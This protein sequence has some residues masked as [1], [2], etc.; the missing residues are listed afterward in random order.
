MWWFREKLDICRLHLA[1]FFLGRFF[2]WVVWMGGEV[3]CSVRGI[4][5]AAFFFFSFSFPSF[6]SILSFQSFLL[7][8]LYSFLRSMD[9]ESVR[10]LCGAFSFIHSSI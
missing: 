8:N 3:V 5:I 4:F 2:W 9:C 7:Y 6:F 10:Y 1:I